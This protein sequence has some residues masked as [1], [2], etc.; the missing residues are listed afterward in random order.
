MVALP[1]EVAGSSNTDVCDH[2]WQAEGDRIALVG[3]AWNDDSLAGL[4]SWHY[5]GASAS[6]GTSVGAR[7]LK[8]S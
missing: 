4:W 2:Y 5:D 1:V 6:Y 7:L 8:T 3:G